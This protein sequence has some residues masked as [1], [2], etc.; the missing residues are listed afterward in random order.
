MISVTG[1]FEVSNDVHHLQPRRSSRQTHWTRA[2][3]RKST[4][5]GRPERCDETHLKLTVTVILDPLGDH[6][7]V[8]AARRFDSNEDVFEK[9]RKKQ[10]QWV[11]SLPASAASNSDHSPEG[12]SDPAAH[13]TPGEGGRQ[14]F[15]CNLLT[16]TKSTGKEDQ[17]PGDPEDKYLLLAT[18]I[19][20]KPDQTNTAHIDCTTHEFRVLQQEPQSIEMAAAQGMNTPSGATK[21]AYRP[22]PLSATSAQWSATAEASE[23]SDNTLTIDTR[24]EVKSPLSTIGDSFEELDQLE[25]EIEAI[26]NAAR[27]VKFD[28]RRVQDAQAPAAIRPAQKSPGRPQVK[29]NVSSR[30]SPARNASSVLG[31][32]KDVSQTP[33]AATLRKVTRPA[34]LA[35]P[36]PIQKARKQPTIPTFEL[37]GERV[38]R[39]LKEK[40]AARLSMQLDAQKAAEVSPPQRTRS[41]RSSKPPTVPNF[42]LPGERYSRQKKERLEKKLKEEEE[43]ARRRRQFKARP[44]PANAAPTIRST[45]TSRQRQTIGGP[46]EQASA[47]APRAG[48]SPKA[49]AAKRQS[50]TMTPMAMR[51]ASIAS[52]STIS[53]TGRG[54]TSSVG[55]SHVSTR[56]TSSSGGSVTSAGKRSILSI[57][58]IQQQKARGR[59]IYT[60]DN[61]VGQARAREEQDRK[62]AIKLARQKYAEMSRNK[63]AQGRAARSLLQQPSS[64]AEENVSVASGSPKG[65]PPRVPQHVYGVGKRS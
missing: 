23:D 60:R 19:D 50:V 31:S 24:P 64:R 45:F 7:L 65:V 25:D 40:K 63:A 28:D 61:T 49:G 26:A 10:F 30:R 42:E 43:E 6:D 17:L 1:N 48:S 4:K 44:S 41:I 58:E 18:P 51:T 32:D 54:R 55:S 29:A 37:P 53:T 62:E 20:L 27:Q 2:L 38:A 12:I 13:H 21:S 35:P 56:A 22:S 33:P 59:Q 52:T 5:V 14:Y 8:R 34:S 16:W 39:E 46:S 36:K 11:L 3:T 15:G 9:H 57:E 47:F